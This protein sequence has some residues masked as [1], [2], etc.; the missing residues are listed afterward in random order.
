VEKRLHATTRIVELLQRSALL[1]PA[2]P[3]IIGPDGAVLTYAALLEQ[4]DRIVRTLIAA[5]VEPGDRVAVVG[6]SGPETAVLFLAVAAIAGCAPLNP[7]YTAAEFEFYLHDL[8][9][10]LL[11]FEEGLSPAAVAVAQ[12]LRVPILGIT[13]DGG[14][15]GTFRFAGAPRAARHAAFAAA[16]DVALVLHTSGTTARPKM[17]PLT[18]KNLCAS[19]NN[20]ARFL[21]LSP[22]DRCLSVMPLFHIHGLVGAL[23]A[24]FAAS[25]SLACA[26]IFRPSDFFGW[27]GALRPTWYT[28]VPSM[29]AAV[30]ER[31]ASIIDAPATHRLR[32]IRSCSAPLPPRTLAELEDLFGVPVVEAYGMTEAAHQM[33]CNPLPPSRRKP[34]SAG[35]ASGTDMAVMDTAGRLL[36][37]GGEGEIVTRGANVMGGYAGGV[38]INAA[39]FTD[40]WFRTGDQGRIDADG[41]LFIT[42]RIK[43]IIN[44][45]GEKVSPREVDEVL[46]DHPAV[47]EAV[48]FAIRDPRVGEEIG[49]A[50]VLRP[51]AERPDARSLLAFA[52][53][54]LA[55]FKLP[56]RILFVGEIPKGPTGKP[57]RMG[58]AA[59][60]GLDE[61]EA[62]VPPTG[63][64]RPRSPT[65]LT[66]L[67][68]LGE[69]IQDESIG[70]GDNFFDCGAD[71]LAALTLLF[72]IEHHWGVRMTVAD[73]L[74]APTVEGLARI[75]DQATPARA[76]PRL[77][78]VHAG[79]S[80]PPFFFIG[81]GPNYRELAR[82][83][84]P[85]QPFFGTLHP[86]PS[87][88]PHPCTIGNM[89]DH[90]LR[91][92]RE[93]QPR[94]PYFLGGFC[95]DGLVAYEVAQRLRALGEPVGLL[96][97][98]DTSFFTS[99]VEAACERM[100]LRKDF[101][102]AM[103]RQ[104]QWRVILRKLLG[105]LG[106]LVGRP[107]RRCERSEAATGPLRAR[108]LEDAVRLRASVDYRPRPCDG[109]MLLLQRSRGQTSWTRARQDWGRLARG[110]FDACAVPGGHHD[111]FDEPRV[112]VTAEKLSAA[113]RDAQ[114]VT[115][116]DA[117]RGGVIRADAA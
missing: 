89:A 35:I 88:E 25:G 68:L 76:P 47:A 73:M 59:R 32:F 86:H 48:T 67:R 53:A 105:R 64:A 55:S 96:V 109:R 108:W 65:E 22:A 74:S 11:I 38:E 37:P 15:A 54:R 27:L 79:G 101:V 113:L 20:I 16:E 114:R 2:A 60:L 21:G 71:S 85:E 112:A 52:E 94:G 33:T 42:G 66:L 41:Y 29:H 39:A 17:V 93:A 95:V 111:M 45:G 104:R 90:H 50:V 43:E 97:L 77:A 1:N 18:Q 63:T 87:V 24:T 70:V 84:G 28:A 46:L 44:R 49:A 23:L 36:P 34:G 8:S 14:A 75:V 103:V 62:V 107:W 58:L 10:R 40:G 72:E 56:R 80:C 26:G 9:P 51:E 92:I 5:G 117:M 98:F 13:P 100:R 78:V 110:G 116:N 82:L 102:V 57:Q 61:P 83:L 12:K 69:A 19:A 81:A 115:R 106:R 3:A 99:R 30:L 6:A 91:I 31:A 4:V 7:T